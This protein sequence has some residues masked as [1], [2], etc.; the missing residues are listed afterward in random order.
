[1]STHLNIGIITQARMTSTRLPG[2]I[3][4]E[5]NHKNLLQYHIDRL[6]QTGFDIA[7]ATTI[8]ATDDCVCEFAE[9]QQIK[10]HRGSENNVLSRFHETATKFKFD[11]IVRVTSDCPLIDPHL[12][13]NSLE[14]YLKF[15]NTN[16]YM[17]NGVERT[18][19][20]GF[21]FEIFSFQLLDAAFKNAKEESDLEHVTP[22]IWKNKSGKVELYHVKQDINNSGLRI[23]V[24]TQ[25]DFNLIKILIEKYNA[26]K[27]AYNEIEEILSNHPE[28][29]AINSHIEQKKV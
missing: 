13:R 23:T 18:F 20:R 26:D 8:N 27:L 21:D 2:K 14:K 6:K 17:S 22:Y 19:A 10:F 11:I 3:F 24:D 7:I 5:I 15:N 1:M 25:D 12:I 16:L 4:K 29:V 28:L 9:K